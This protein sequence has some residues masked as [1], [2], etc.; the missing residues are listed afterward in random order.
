M[1]SR[2]WVP[3]GRGLTG[4][5]FFLKMTALTGHAPAACQQISPTA[6]PSMAVMAMGA[7]KKRMRKIM[8]WREATSRRELTLEGDGLHLV[9][10][11]AHSALNNVSLERSNRSADNNA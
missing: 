5:L 8:P 2:I 9:F 3:S 10:A 11:A 6:E 4:C 1:D 7:W